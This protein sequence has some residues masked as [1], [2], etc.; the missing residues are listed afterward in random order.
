MKIM[1]NNENNALKGNKL[2]ENVLYNLNWSNVKESS[3]IV[4]SGGMQV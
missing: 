1:Q 4:Q 2:T 3:R